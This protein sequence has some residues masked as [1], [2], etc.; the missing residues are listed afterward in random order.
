MD[1]G[2]KLNIEQN[3]LILSTFWKIY[4]E[5]FIIKRWEGH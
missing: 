1:G 3:N 2:T 4:F 5:I